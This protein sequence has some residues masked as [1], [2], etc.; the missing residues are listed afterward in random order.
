MIPYHEFQQILPVAISVWKLCIGSPWKSHASCK[1][2]GFSPLFCFYLSALA[3]NSSCQC[4]VLVRLFRWKRNCAFFSSSV[5]WLSHSYKDFQEI[6]FFCFS[7]C[8]GL[9]RWYFFFG[10]NLSIYC[11]LKTCK[12]LARTFFCLQWYWPSAWGVL[13]P[14]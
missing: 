2:W 10:S 13:K 8:Q 9:Q 6:C 12:R 3:E 11:V 5:I 7:L 1:F 4:S 14:G